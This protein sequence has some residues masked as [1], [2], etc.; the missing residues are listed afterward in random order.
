MA[1][2]CATSFIPPRFVQAEISWERNASVIF[3]LLQDGFNRAVHLRRE[4]SAEFPAVNQLPHVY[5]PIQFFAVFE[6]ARLLL[7]KHFLELT[8]SQPPVGV[9]KD[10]KFPVEAGGGSAGFLR[11]G[12]V[13]QAQQAD[14]ERVSRQFEK[15]PVRFVVLHDIADIAGAEAAGLRRDYRGLGG[16]QGV[17]AGQHEVALGGTAHGQSD[18]AGEVFGTTKL[19]VVQPSLVIG[20]EEQYPGGAGYERLAVAAY[21]QSVLGGLFI[22][23][24]DGIQHQVAGCRRPQGCANDIRFYLF[25]DGLGQELAG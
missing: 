13:A 5:G 8:F 11:L 21:S 14:G 12:R 23:F 17:T 1:F 3:P 10:D 4:V 7:L 15:V 16:Y 19:E 24:D 25:R 18:T 22:Y 6:S 9:L 2:V 20:Q